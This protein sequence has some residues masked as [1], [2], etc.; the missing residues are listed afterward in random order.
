MAYTTI[1]DPEAYFQTLLYSG[2]DSSSRAL[3]NDG[4]SD[5]QPDLVWIKER[6][7][8]SGHKVLDSVRGGGL[9]LTANTTAGDESFAFLS[10]FDSDGFTIGTS[11]G[12]T[13]ASGD[14]YV[15][16]QWKESATAGFDIVTYTGNGTDDTDISH[17]LSATPKMI[18]IKNRD[19]ADAW[20]V[21]HAANTTSPETDYLVL[22]TNAVTA[23]AADRWSD[24]APTS[25]VFT[26][27]DA[28][29][30]NTDTED[31][32]AYCFAD[33]QGYSK[34]GSYTGNG[35]TDG[36][37]VYTGFRPAF[38]LHKRTDSI[39]RANWLLFDNKRGG[40][41]NYGSGRDPLSPDN[42]GNEAD[43]TGRDWIDLL[44]NGFKFRGEHPSPAHSTNYG[45]DDGGTYVFI[46]FAEAPFVNSNGVPCNAR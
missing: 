13:N 28:D 12:S 7:S 8:T 22:D 31:Y 25:S 15:A 19:A 42:S 16:W 46:A 27:G 9:A 10:S 23:D 14:T 2:N 41:G 38:I 1:D 20:Q 45:H 36:T 18:I 24:E 21:Y 35:S 37:F 4:N 33:V 6:S 32:I 30:V 40:S 11:D 29:E 44:S 26:L 43:W 39:T 34:I 17:N 3:T 5:L